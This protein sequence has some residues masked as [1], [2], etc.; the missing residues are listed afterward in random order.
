MIVGASPLGAATARMLIA[1]RHDVVIIDRDRATLDALGESMDCGFI[2]GDG[3]A[4]ASLRHAR[5][6]ENAALLSLTNHDEDN[7]LAALLG[8][9][10]GYDRVI[11]KIVNAELAELCEELGLD[12]AL[13]ADETMA[14][15]LTDSLQQDAAVEGEAT[16]GEGL[17]LMRVMAEDSHAGPAG[18]LDLPKGARLVSIRGDDGARLAEPDSEIAEGDALVLA[19]DDDAAAALRKRGT[20][21]GSGR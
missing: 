3:A 2:H 15:S 13:F 8:R 6:D 12:D 14:A 1:A 18:E 21:G 17:R 10:V 9:S 16:L 11:P 7:V 19:V 20:G 4:P 5:G